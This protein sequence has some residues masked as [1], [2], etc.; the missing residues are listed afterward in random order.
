MSVQ[1]LPWVRRGLAAELGHVDDGAALPA[2]ATFPVRVTV[3]G[4]P[5]TVSI[6]S[7]GPGEVTGLVNRAISRTSPSRFAT[8]VAPDEFAAVEF[9]EPDLPWM[10]TPATAGAEQRLRPWLVLVV[11][12][13]SD[14]VSVDL[15]RTR[16]LPTL[17]IEPPAVPADELPDLSQ[18]WAW[19]HAQVITAQ[20]SDSPTAALDGVRG[21]R[22]SRLLCPRR[23]QPHASYI[24][25]LVPAFDLGVDAGLGRTNGSTT[26]A[27]A[28]DR[29]ALGDSIT[30]P[31]YHH[32]EFT[33]GPAGDFESLARLLTPTFVP[34]GVGS[35]PL[36]I[37]SAHPA[38]PPLPAAG[39]GVVPME[40]ALRAPAS[41]TG[42][43]LDQ[44]HRAW[45]DALTA[46]VNATADAASGGTASDAEAVAPPVYGQW[47]VNVHR[48]PGRVNRPRWLR[49]LNADPRHR[50]AAGLGA[51]VVRANQEDYV[52]AAWT[53][54]GDVLAAIRVLE[55]SRGIAAV[56]ARVH[57]RHIEGIDP[58]RALALF[59]RAQFRLPFLNASLGAAI[60]RSASLPGFNTRNF[61]RLASPRNG[62]LRK[63][64]RRLDPLSMG[65]SADIAGLAG[66]PRGELTPVIDQLPDG[67]RTTALV[68]LAARLVDAGTSSLDEALVGSL[69]TKLTG[70]ID[71]LG[72]A[73]SPPV[74]VRPDLAAVGVITDLHV[75]QVLSVSTLADDVVTR[76][77]ELRS[78]VARPRDTTSPLI[79]VLAGPSGL[80]PV[81]IEAGGRVV[82]GSGS[83]RVDITAP[84][85]A[86]VP[87]VPVVAGLPIGTTTGR[88]AAP[89]A[90]PTARGPIGPR[91]RPTP[92]GPIA[93]P[94]PTT[95]DALVV[96][97]ARP[98]ATLISTVTTIAPDATRAGLGRAVA[99]A[100]LDLGPLGAAIGVNAGATPAAALSVIPPPDGAPTTVARF[101]DGFE[102][103]DRYATT[104][105][106]L[107]PAAADP[108]PLDLAA[109]RDAIVETSRP[110]PVI[111][112][113]L[114]TRLRAGAAPF[115]DAPFAG[116]I[117]VEQPDPVLPIMVGP[118][119][120]RPLY[121]DLA[122]FDQNRFLPGGGDLPDNSITMLET[123]PRFVESFMT[124]ANHEFNRELLW[125]RYP[126][127]R[128][129]TAFLR[130]WDRVDD[131]DDI[132]PIHTWPGANRLGSNS[133]GDPDGSVVLVVRG[134][135]LRRYPNTVVSAIAATADRRIDNTATP[136]APVF[137]GFL[138]PD[139]TFVGFDFDLDT[140]AAGH[141]TMFVL[142]EQ[143]SEPRFGLDVPPGALPAAATAPPAT[144]S[145]LTWGD[146][147]IAPGGHLDVNA[148]GGN[149][150][151]PITTAAP[152]VTARFGADSSHMAAITFQRP[153]RA[154]VHSSEI[155]R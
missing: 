82:A 20:R 112:A 122:K 145:D 106:Q 98:D 27:P 55:L 139:I 58:V 17:T 40:G 63:A 35:S 125:R 154:A 124:G 101:V 62:L 25:A 37:G 153:F 6:E 18:S 76:V 5:A 91:M 94:V 146:V 74:K 60:D 100:T 51:E 26:A 61:R 33:T 113:R 129:G 24:A 23:L 137:A 7:F 81:T 67:L 36:Y 90:A 121:L 22:L 95:P 44:R 31:V 38:L 147:A 114:A 54:V 107:L 140:A 103:H 13:Q 66:V 64:E 15:D 133:V 29:A 75:A 88:P 1:F 117:R 115:G 39:G 52:D 89:V 46:V 142:Q 87:S 128:R 48:I 30:L 10:F 136:I 86:M 42:T 120:D 127:D 134:Q 9:G 50:A 152:T 32:W 73:P 21:Q 150:E 83:T 102:A 49:D 79:G 99:T 12:T 43:E 93:T 151:R 144:W 119:L 4:Q 77:V 92:A 56:V 111:E 53:Q 28:W 105:G 70:H 68:D 85:A 116:R 110:R 155:V 78:A 108:A 96:G 118:A 47:H 80:A 130:F 57:S 3:N 59:D 97:P 71:D 143:P 72:G 132:E 109:A 131:G 19:A 84:V 69:A 148:F 11:V 41:G 104:V 126:T 34:A 14:G 2:R 123:N 138:E 16:P 45:V 141:G 149:P 8:N 135:L 65:K